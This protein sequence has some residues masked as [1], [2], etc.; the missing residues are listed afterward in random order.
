M[1]RKQ[2]DGQHLGGKIVC[3]RSWRGCDKGIGR[4][5]QQ[6]GINGEG[7]LRKPRLKFGC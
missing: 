3:N 5:K 1:Q 2:K 6:M 7:F 4:D